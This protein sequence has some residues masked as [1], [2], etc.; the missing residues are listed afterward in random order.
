MSCLCDQLQRLSSETFDWIDAQPEVKEESITDWLLYELSKSCK[1]VAYKS[2]TRHEEAKYTGADWDWIFVFTDGAVRLRV[3]AKKLFPSADNYPGLARANRY[4]QQIT[5][6][7]SSAKASSSYP[8]YAFY[9]STTTHN[10]CGG[11]ESG[12]KNGTYLCGAHLVDTQFVKART[13]VLDFDVIAKSYPMPCIACCTLSSSDSAK[14]LIEQIHHYF[15]IEED[16]PSLDN[17][18]LGYLKDIPAFASSV[19]RNDLKFPESWEKEF[20]REFSEV[21]AVV[22]VDNRAQLFKQDD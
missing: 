5:K 9:S 11:D 15:P 12:N 2:F 20:T 18:L 17:R 16:S 19:L 22:I 14:S 8:I 4:G 6:L 21:S 13:T 1:N 7:I 3:Q 10:C